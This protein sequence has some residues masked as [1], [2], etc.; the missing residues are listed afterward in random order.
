MK[1]SRMHD[2]LLFRSLAGCPAILPILAWGIAVPSLWGQGGEIP[3]PQLGGG[4]EIRSVSVYA[5]YYSSSLPNSGSFQAGTPTLGAD[6]A[7]GGSTQ[8]EWTKYSERSSFSLS[9]IPSYTGRVQYSEWNALNHAFS[10][11]TGRKLT[12]R[13]N[14]S[15]S[16]GADLSSLDQFL[17]APTVFSTAA[18]VPA[19]FNDLSAAMLGKNFSNPQLASALTAAPLADSPAR[20][21][22]YGE[23]VFTSGVQSS[24]SYSWSPRLLVNFSGSAGRTQRVWENRAGAPQSAYLVPDTT[25]GNVGLGVSYAISPVT[26]LGGNV[27]TSRIV[28]SLQDVYTTTTT[29]SLGRSFAERW[30]LELHGGVGVANPVRQTSY[31]RLS[32]TPRPVAGG[33]LGFKTF[34]HTVLGSYGRTVSDSYGVGAATSSSSSVSWRWSQ[35]GRAWWLESSLGWEQL[36]GGALADN[37]TW[38]ANAGLGRRMSSNVVL[39][40]QY[41]YLD[42][43]GRL[44]QTAYSQSQNAVRLSVMWNPRPGLF[45]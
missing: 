28:S 33:S 17:F 26:Q 11:N 35:P 25:S 27:S 36:Q 34:T 12:P 39:L 4:L 40:V 16:V 9:Y 44:E 23:R 22:I 32:T 31:F 41:V 21:L 29:A 20:N 38:R 18:S 24:L 30:F 1:D 45:R 8:I 13:F 6:L 42:Y 19:S 43:L 10:L 3:E 5:A 14:L 37:S 2:M 15:F 7:V